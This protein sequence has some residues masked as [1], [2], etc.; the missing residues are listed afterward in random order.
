[1][2]KIKLKSKMDLSLKEYAVYATIALYANEKGISSISRDSLLNLTGLK[3]PDT[4]TEYTNKFVELGLLEKEYF[5]TRGKKLVRYHLL[6]P[7]ANYLWVTQKVFCGNTELT[8]FLIKL[9][10]MRYS[11]SSHVYLTNVEII[12]RMKI[13]KNTFYKLIKLAI[14]GNYIS[15]NEYGYV[16]DPETFPLCKSRQAKDK[17]ENIM[18]MSPD[19][20]ERKTLLTYY[21]PFTGEFSS[22]IGDVDAFLDY[23]LSGVPKHN[24]Q[25][26]EEKIPK[27]DYKF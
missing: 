10:E 26:F 20:R 4:I 23:C 27:I 1:M 15:K 9:A 19:S 13:S 3:T 12:K 7:N 14:Q 21:D 16:I 2:K 11:Y 8:G 6:I 22:K 25:T 17:I 5:F 24:K 18:Q